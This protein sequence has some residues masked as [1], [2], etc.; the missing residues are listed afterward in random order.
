MKILLDLSNGAYQ[1]IVKAL[2]SP[3]RV[4]IL[5]FISERQIS[6]KV[7]LIR[8]MIDKGINMTVI[9]EAFSQTESNISAQVRILEDAGL[10][11]CKHIPGDHGISKLPFLSEIIQVEGE[12]E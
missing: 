7:P 1:T 10:I 12:K 5:R 8:D 3:T 4:K 9:A 6:P 11:Y 2:K